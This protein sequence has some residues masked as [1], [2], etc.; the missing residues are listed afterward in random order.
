MRR[1]LSG[2]RPAY[3]ANETNHCPACSATQWIIGRLTAECACCGA[4]LP[5]LS[6]S[7]PGTGTH[8]RAAG[9]IAA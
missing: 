1:M 8:R 2:Y 5:L 7:A 6:G 3:R 9:R 4:A